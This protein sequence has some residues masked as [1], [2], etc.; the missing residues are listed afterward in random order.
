[1]H[2]ARVAI[3]SLEVDRLSFDDAVARII[4]LAETKRGG[5]IVTPNV[6]HVVLAEHD[7]RFRAAYQHAAL[8][9]C[10]GFPLLLTSRLL[11]ATLPEKISGSDLA[12]PVLQ[13]AAARNLRVFFLGAAP[14]VA[15]KARAKVAE[16]LP[17]LQ[18]VGTSSPMVNMD[19][20]PSARDEIVA[21]LNAAQPHIVFV[22]FGAPKQELLCYEIAERV[23]PAVLLGIGATLDFLAG[24]VKRAPSWMSRVGLEWVY[25]LAHEPKRMAHRYLVRDTQYPYIVAKR[26]LIRR[27]RGGS[28]EGGRP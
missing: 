17:A 28:N 8:S 25:R 16:M 23:K 10:D 11:G 4:E 1:M 13:Q 2:P 18:V 6:D 12:M 27:V 3:G 22:A 26:A 21:E 5:Y 15:E 7:A 14:G 9:V 24:T 20:P 19:H